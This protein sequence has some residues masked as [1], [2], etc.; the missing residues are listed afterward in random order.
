MY[1][2]MYIYVCMYVYMYIHIQYK[3]CMACTDV[4]IYVQRT[5]R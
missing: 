2:Y 4:K 5:Y 1:I 3:L